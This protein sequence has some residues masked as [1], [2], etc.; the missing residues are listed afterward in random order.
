MQDGE[1]NEKCRMLPYLFLYPK[2]IVILSLVLCLG[3][4]TTR[5]RI[6][7]WESSAGKSNTVLAC[8]SHYEWSSIVA[9]QWQ[10]ESRNAYCSHALFDLEAYGMRRQFKGEDCTTHHW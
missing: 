10:M 7:L 1:S 8:D 5:E 4:C 9:L 2:K 6:L 3:S